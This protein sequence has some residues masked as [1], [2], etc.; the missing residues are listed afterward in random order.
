[1]SISAPFRKKD[2]PGSS[3]FQVWLGWSLGFFLVAALF[4]L[5]MRY[6]TVGELPAYIDYKN[7]LHT[8]SHVAL[9][10]WGYLTTSAAL[11]Y[12]FVPDQQK[13][14][15][16]YPLVVLAILANLGMV[17]S[18]PVQ[19][20]GTYSI[21]ASVLHML[22][23]FA[24]AFKFWKDIRKQPSSDATQLAACSVLWMVVSS[25]GLL[26]IGPVGSLMGRLHPMFFISIQWFLHF[27][28]NG[29]FVYAIFS[30]LAFRLAQ[31]GKSLSLCNW[32]WAILHGSLFLSFSLAVSWSTP[33]PGLLYINAL[34][35]VLQ[36]IAYIR[37]LRP[38]WSD[39]VS[40]ENKTWIERLLLLGIIFL[41]AKA[42]VQSILI[43]TPVAVIAYTI[44]MY[45][46][47]FIHLIMLGA[48]TFTI[49][50][51]LLQKSLFSNSFLAK[52]GWMILVSGFVLTE[53]L[54]FGQGTLLWIKA[55]FI[56]SFYILL[57]L[58]SALLP[59]GLSLITIAQIFNIQSTF[60]IN[61]ILNSN[62]TMKK[63]LTLAVGATLLL[64]A[65][66]GGGD[67]SSSTSAPSSTEAEAPK[68]ADPNGVGEIKDVAIS[69][70]IDDGMADK[71]KAIMDMKC[72]ACH[73]FNDK[74]LVGPGFQGVTN[75]R[76]PEWIM[77][78]IT[79]VEVMLDKDP[80]AQALLEECLTRMP[81]QNIS[82]ADARNIL[83]YLRKNDLEKAGEK[84]GAI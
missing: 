31:K 63:S 1:M 73:Q 21:A 83:E 38:V 72:T 3:L 44:R 9:L 65:S 43:L 78:M 2:N 84:D 80:V 74:R 28:L 81:N 59:L 82:L 12:F 14:K 70:E 66:C 32:D 40:E 50:S 49:S 64:F 33:I 69:E 51:V 48:M 55:G 60:K 5:A 46:I 16:Y 22:V 47:G 25:L 24:F 7:L 27:Q 56:P 15:S 18:F 26:S 52:T 77:N 30:I 10:G 53:L 37:I 57:F 62:Q 29:W 68:A 45:V 20:Y 41:F 8:H 58:A 39:L 76:R 17:L 11:V 35:V 13:Q 54:L 23:S 19:G 34:A 71:G 67:G 6:F 36:L 61:S 4:G 42:L 75:R 79:N